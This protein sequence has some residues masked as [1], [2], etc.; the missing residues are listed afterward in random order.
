MFMNTWL[1][2]IRPKRGAPARTSAAERAIVGSFLEYAFSYV[3]SALP[4]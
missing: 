4:P 1:W 3:K 2:A